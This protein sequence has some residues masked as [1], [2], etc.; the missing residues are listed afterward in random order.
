M[1]TSVSLINFASMCRLTCGEE[2]EEN[3][4]DDVEEEEDEEKR[5]QRCVC[6]VVVVDGSNNRVF[7][8]RVFLYL[9]LCRE[10]VSDESSTRERE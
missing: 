5:A 8:C 1:A 6:I 10:C 2:E 7:L 9:L 3:D 4:D